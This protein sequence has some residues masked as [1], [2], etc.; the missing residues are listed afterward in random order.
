MGE[1]RAKVI[2]QNDRD[3]FLHEQGKIKKDQIREVKID[4]LVDTGAVM[5]LLP[6]DIV[7]TLG[8]GKIEKAI[9]VLANEAK[10]EM[11]VM[12]P[13]ALTIANRRMTTDCL[14]GPPRCEP[15]IG[16]LVME[17]LDLV[18]DPLKRTLTARPESPY[19]PLLKL[20]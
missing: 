8:L 13:I 6:Q 19:L 7:E 11:D 14:M 1:I 9:V 10:I 15:L 3:I 12:G 17:R 2:L 18:I 5:I 16:Q 20:K 4:A